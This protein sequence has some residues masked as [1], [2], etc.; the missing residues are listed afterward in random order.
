M[1]LLLDTE[2]NSAHPGQ[3]AQLSYILV[4]ESWN[5]QQSQNYFFRVDEMDRFAQA[6][7]GFSLERLEELSQGKTF[8]DQS[9]EIIPILDQHTLVAHNVGFD[10]KFIQYEYQRLWLVYEPATL[11]TMQHFTPICR[12]PH[13]HNGWYK[14]P[15]LGELLNHYSISESQVQAMVQEL[16]DGENTRAHD[17]RYDT[18]ALYLVMQEYQKNSHNI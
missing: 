11:C 9:E 13:H 1:Y 14:R 15:K 4:D 5:F 3:I 16:F 6:I 2:T 17:A 10:K 8:S 7:H 18:T 12:L